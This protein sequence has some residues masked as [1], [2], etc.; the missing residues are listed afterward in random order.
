ML[1]NPTKKQNK[2]KPSELFEG[3]NSSLR[4]TFDNIVAKDTNVPTNDSWVEE[5]REDMKRN[6][7]SLNHQVCSRAMTID[8]MLEYI[9]PLI[10]K[11]IAKEK[12]KSYEEGYE[13]GEEDEEELNQ[14]TIAKEREKP[15]TFIGISQWLEYGKQRG[16]PAFFEK[17]GRDLVVK[18]LKEIFNKCKTEKGLS[19]A[20]S[21]FINK[22]KYK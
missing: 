5:F 13:K 9:I 3:E 15:P 11:T 14:I 12:T 18:D 1:N 16:F 10:S 19:R 17:K 4:K 22:P 7:G 21:N 20:L 2:E 6:Y 8:D